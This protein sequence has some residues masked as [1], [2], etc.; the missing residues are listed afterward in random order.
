MSVITQGEVQ[1][2]GPPESASGAVPQ[3]FCVR[4]AWTV[5]CV[6]VHMVLVLHAF[7]AASDFCSF[8]LPVPV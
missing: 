8:S 2:S 7:V 4:F 3:G 1:L 6:V 5:L